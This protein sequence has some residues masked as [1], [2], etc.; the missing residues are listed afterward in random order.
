M[1]RAPRRLVAVGEE[2]RRD[3]MQVVAFRTEVVV[4]DVDQHHEPARVRRVD[5][6]FRSSGVP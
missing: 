4:D 2:R 1:R 5:Q 3:A 6:R